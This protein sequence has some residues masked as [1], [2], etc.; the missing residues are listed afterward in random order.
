MPAQLLERGAELVAIAAR[1]DAATT[2]RGALLVLEGP[3][4]IGKSSLLAA[5]G[6]LAGARGM[7]VLPARAAPLEQAYGF[8]VVRQLFEPVR[9]GCDP[10]EWEGLTADAAGLALRALDPGPADAAPGD[11]VAHATLHGLFWLTANLAGRR[12]LVVAVDDAH[13]ADPP[14]LRWLGSLARRLDDLPLVAVIAVRSGEPASDPSLLDDLLGE[15]HGLA[16]RPRPLGPAAAEALVQARLPGA[17]PAFC[18][19]CH[20]A[21]GGNPFHLHALIASIVTEGAVPDAT[22]AASLERFGPEAIARAVDRQLERLPEGA[23]ELAR[24]VAVLGE[25]PA[26]REAAAVADLEPAHAAVLS[27]RLRTA[28]LLAPAAR[29][30]FAHPILR[31]AVAAGLGPAERRLWHGRAARILR[32]DGADAE[33]VALQLLEAEPAADPEAVEALRA[34]ARA[35]TSRGTPETAAPY[36]RRAL[37]E[38]PDDRTRPQ[39][40]LELGLA[41]AAYRHHDAPALLREAIDLI[42]DPPTRG[43]A[44]LRAAR[45]L[46]LAALYADEVELCRAT[47]AGAAD[48]PPDTVARLEAELIGMA[49]TRA[50]TLPEARER[51]SRS[52][53]APPSVPLWRIT[54][55]AIDTFDARPAR[56]SVALVRPLLSEAALAGE[57]E[58]LLVSVVL[59]LVL[60]WNDELDAATTAADSQLAAARP[61]GWAS[62]VANGS[63]LRGMTQL[64]RGNVAEAE[65]DLR[66]AFGFKLTVSP[67]DSLAWALAPFVDALRERDALDAADEALDAGSAGVLTPDLLVFPQVHEAR[68]RLRLAQRRPREALADARAAGASFAEL[69]IEGPGV[70]TWRLCAAEALVALGERSEAATL[71]GEQLALAER[72]GAPGPL[73]AALRAVALSAPRAAA[74]APLERA[75][76]VLAPS[77]AQL[78]HLHALCDLGAALRR[79]SRHEAARAPLRRALD[80]A[81]R[82]GA[83]R[84]AAR[85]RAE[86]RDT[87]AR[88]RRAALSGRDA[89]TPAERRVAALAA[90][91]HTNRQIAQQLFVTQRTVETHLTHAFAKLDVTSRDGLPV[92]L[93]P[94]GDERLP[95]AVAI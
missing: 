61:R 87:G 88:P 74:L 23:R 70:N 84:I 47:L 80:L 24:G 3:A 48:M 25:G 60:I 6:E 79:R 10:A 93:W 1:L 2:G 41:L 32:A 21:T 46:A 94:A 59:T 52:R 95:E 22:A 33:R 57:R 63:F 17:A 90:G 75:V 42:P 40:L 71:A 68:A 50:A 7:R 69:K 78:E 14:S 5:A 73:G 35:A 12:P 76:A 86:L 56:E 31:S 72:L 55:A 28:G 67:P 15:P 4:G 9:A 77:Q 82:A 85:A 16:L 26:L 44:G 66:Y 37:A 45:A 89:L 38:P 30:E 53:L 51:V 36:L 54:A 18:V 62:A 65:T 43:A 39:V 91:G 11:D 81:D 34:A 13:W 27:D 29:L 20:A 58:S 92:A 83:V 19:A 49:M 8:G 64:R